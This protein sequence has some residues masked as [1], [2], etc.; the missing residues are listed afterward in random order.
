MTGADDSDSSRSSQPP[1]NL[2]ALDLAEHNYGSVVNELAEEH[3]L[4]YEY[5]MALIV[6]EC[7]GIKPAG[8]R[9]EKG[10]YKK[11]LEVRSGERRKFENI[12]QHHLEGASDEALKNLATS[13]GPFQ[14]MGYKCIALGA[15]VNDIRGDG[16]T[17][18]GVIWIEEEYGK[19]LR[20]GKFK[21][22]FH[23]HNT[24]QKY[25]RSGKP[26]THDPSYVD[27]GLRYIDHYREK[28]TAS[29]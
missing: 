20:K 26:R 2:N 5:L 9:Y 16:A 6:L 10:V 15:Q 3:Q 21:D 19:M 1:P 8:H 7:S 24:G 14:L 29:R 27:R 4:P 13:W 11:L 25:P 23:I 22:A 17:K 12:R 18:W 28:K